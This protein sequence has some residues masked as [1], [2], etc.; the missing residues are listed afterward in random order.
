[1]LN[2][3]HADNALPQSATA[4]V[5]CRILPD[6]EP[7]EVQAKLQEL[8]GPKV[9]V[10]PDPNFI[11]VSTP[12]SP[13]RADVITAVTAAIQRF[14]GPQMHVFPAMSDRRERRLVFRAKGHPRL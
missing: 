12:A 10:K 8:V 13:P 7:N 14:H 2:G 9:E 5:N 1:M 11:G 4:T 3:G 6:V